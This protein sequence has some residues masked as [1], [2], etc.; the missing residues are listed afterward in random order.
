MDEGLQVVV[1]GK[2]RVTFKF[3]G[4]EGFKVMAK[5]QVQA[6]WVGLVR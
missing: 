3:F 6:L 2:T 5:L 1:G 4:N